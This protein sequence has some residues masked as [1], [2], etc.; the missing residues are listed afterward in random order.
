M[1]TPINLLTDFLMD[2]SPAAIPAEVSRQ[3]RL[4]LLDTLGCMISGSETEDAK[5]ISHAET[6]TNPGNIC[7]VAGGGR[8]S[9]L[10]AARI[11]AYQ[12]DIF[13][14]ND[15]IA[16]HASIGNVSA[17]LALAQAQ[18]V[19]GKE[20]QLA[21]IAGIETT[22][23][24]YNAFYPYQK[25]LDEV[26]IVSVGTASTM[27]AAAACSRILDLDANQTTNALAIAAAWA[28][29]CPAEV[30]FGD[31]GSAKPMLFGGLPASN[32]IS[33]ALAAREGVTG[34]IHILSSEK[35]YFATIATSWDESSFRSGDWALASPRR[36]LHACCGYIHS[37]YDLS[38]RLKAENALRPENIASITVEVPDYTLPAIQKPQPPKTPNEARF[39]M[40]YM[41]AQAF[42]GAG[43]VT[44]SMSNNFYE[45][46]SRPEV[47]DLTGRI[48]VI[49]EASLTHY[50][51]SR[52]TVEQIEG[53][54]LTS[55]ND[56][57]RGSAQNPL[58]E[59]ELIAK[60]TGLSTPILGIKRTDQLKELCGDLTNLSEVSE[61]CTL[62]EKIHRP[63]ITQ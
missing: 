52:I 37:A 14:L 47:R 18:R 23:R 8:H 35:G 31:G 36:K 21:L 42:S 12:G 28:N 11:N 43:P 34:P 54:T 55:T 49:G 20:L 30:I 9:L 22:A 38:Q 33:A 62:L 51:H 6:A 25:P 45:E 16:G 40:Q 58:S 24:I 26:G 39:H 4:C 2:L 56:A 57:P 60:F 44:P 1:Q 29:W 48:K 19:S 50:H 46:F 59:E 10:G 3:A 13:E 41:L 27:G 15:L 53:P 32:G 7:S 61:L 63:Q 5:R 17:A